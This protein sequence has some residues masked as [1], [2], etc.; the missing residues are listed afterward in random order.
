[1]ELNHSNWWKPEVE[2]IRVID[3]D[4]QDIVLRPGYVIILRDM[5]TEK[6]GEIFRAPG[7]VKQA[8]VAE[9]VSSAEL[10]TSEEALEIGAK[11]HVHG[12]AR[13]EIRIK[14]GEKVYDLLPREDI[15]AM[16]M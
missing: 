7:S 1:M 14:F 11:V 9:L 10:R 3:M 5:E 4:P 2:R 13:A 6:F 16:E 12:H 8:K 15:I